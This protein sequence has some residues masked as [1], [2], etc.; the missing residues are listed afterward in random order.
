M[1][2]RDFEAA[3]TAAGLCAG[4]RFYPIAVSRFLLFMTLP[5]SSNLNRWCPKAF[6]SPLVAAEPV[7]R[8]THGLPGYFHPV[9]S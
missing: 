3:I 2:V 1:P 6:G 5:I 7:D 8:G 9:R 4:Y